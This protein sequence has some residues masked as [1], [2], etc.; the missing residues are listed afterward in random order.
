MNDDSFYWI[1]IDM[2]RLWF[3]SNISR[4]A[5]LRLYYFSWLL[6]VHLES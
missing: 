5:D 6:I 2:R 1:S 4:E 3:I